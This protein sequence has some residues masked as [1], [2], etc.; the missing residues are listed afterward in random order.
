MIFAEVDEEWARILVFLIV[1]LYVLVVILLLIRFLVTFGP[2]LINDLSNF[3]QN[4]N[5]FVLITAQDI[6]TYESESLP[7][8]PSRDTRKEWRY[9][10]QI[11]IRNGETV[12][13]L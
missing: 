5:Y 13:V 8:F 10:L 12:K 7:R 3:I 4:L 9:F 2:P 11:S 6:S 1:A